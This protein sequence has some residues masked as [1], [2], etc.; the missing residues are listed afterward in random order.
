MLQCNFEAKALQGL[1][2]QYSSNHN[3][4]STGS[5]ENLTYPICITLPNSLFY[6]SCKMFYK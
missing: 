2:R 6:P 4:L 1:S 5:R 3:T